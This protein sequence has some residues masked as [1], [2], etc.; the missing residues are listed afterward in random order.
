[1]IKVFLYLWSYRQ[2]FKFWV[3]PCD[4]WGIKRKV[5]CNVKDF[6]LRRDIAVGGKQYVNTLYSFDHNLGVTWSEKSD[7]L[8]I[9]IVF[10]SSYFQIICAILPWFANQLSN[11]IVKS[12]ASFQ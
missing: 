1:M 9:K 10:F 12:E 4:A 3:K 2:W 11:V 8:S 5:I 6:G 7:F